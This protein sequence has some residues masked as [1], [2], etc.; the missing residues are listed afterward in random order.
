MVNIKNKFNPLKV[1]KMCLYNLS[2]VFKVLELGKG[3]FE[4][5]KV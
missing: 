4:K 5:K 3:S 1:H 2:L